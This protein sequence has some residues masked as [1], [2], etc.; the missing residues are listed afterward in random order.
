[1]DKLQ[2]YFFDD[3]TQFGPSEAEEMRLPG[4]EQPEANEPEDN[5][6]KVIA[7]LEKDTTDDG[8][9][10]DFDALIMN[11]GQRAVEEAI[12]IEARQMEEM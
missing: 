12:E 7:L 2:M 1:M 6:H 11:F 5:V 9:G 4:M 8:S 3:G 10:V